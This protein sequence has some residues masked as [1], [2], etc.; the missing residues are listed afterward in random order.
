[1]HSN[2]IQPSITPSVHL[3]NFQLYTRNGKAISIPLLEPNK[4]WNSPAFDR[5]VNTTLVVTG[6]NSNVNSTNEAIETLHR[7]YRQQNV[8]FVVSQTLRELKG[9][10]IY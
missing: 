1:M 3:M 5:T 9:I 6:W 7:A 8:N 10:R 2:A 4:L